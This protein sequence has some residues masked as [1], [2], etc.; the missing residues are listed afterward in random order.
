MS[1]ACPPRT[2]TASQLCPY[3]IFIFNL[4]SY[5]WAKPGPDHHGRLTRRGKSDV[6][7]CCGVSGIVIN[8][9]VLD[10]TG[11]GE[12]GTEVRRKKGEG[13]ANLQKSS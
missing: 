6:D 8:F 10:T 5:L 3:L 1:S 9:E 11:Y 13:G 2:C 4:I 12:R 7:L